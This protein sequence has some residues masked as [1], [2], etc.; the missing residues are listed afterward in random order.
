MFRNGRS[1]WENLWDCKRKN[2][3][4]YQ[5]GNNKW[6]QYIGAVIGKLNLLNV[7]IYSTDIF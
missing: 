1:S 2:V 7:G 6:L 5:V 3:S 4:H